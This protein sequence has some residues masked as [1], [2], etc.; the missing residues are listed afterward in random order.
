MA[1]EL[2]Y[3]EGGEPLD[4]QNMPVTSE[5]IEG[6]VAMVNCSVDPDHE[7]HVVYRELTDEEKKQGKADRTEAVSFQRVNAAIFLRLTRDAMLQATDYLV[8]NDIL[9]DEWGTWRQRLRDLP[10]T[11]AD[12]GDVEWPAPPEEISA[13]Y[14]WRGELYG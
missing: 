5:P 4:H 13:L 8:L 12:P 9:T 2:A 11:V 14:P 7:A 1:N 3:P 10:E 6:G